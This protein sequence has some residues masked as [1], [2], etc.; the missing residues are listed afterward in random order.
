MDFEA[1]L[2]EA[3][4]DAAAYIAAEVATK[5]ENERDFYCGFAWVT[6]DGNEPLARWCRAKLKAL[7][8]NA[9]YFDKAKFGDRGYPKG[10]QFWKPG[11]FNGQSVRIHEV[12]ARGFRDA[13]AR[14]GIRAV[15]G[16]RL[17]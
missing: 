9:V 10:W 17:D 15:V 8:S 2:T 12:G 16:S 11:N 4:R 6:I 3:H 1:I 14:Y 5:P 7:P 13:L